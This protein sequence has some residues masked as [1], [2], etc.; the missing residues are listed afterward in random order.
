MASASN[1][2][3]LEHFQSEVLQ[4]IV[5]ASWYVPNTVI[6]RELQT[7]TVKEETCHCSSQYSVHLSVHLNN[8]IVNLLAQPDIMRLQRHLANDLPIRLQVSLFYL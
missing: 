2:E 3:I 6:R 4:T 1:I 8:L 5:D 7:P